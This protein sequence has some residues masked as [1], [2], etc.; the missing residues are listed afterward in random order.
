MR[1]QDDFSPNSHK[2]GRGH[3]HGHH[4]HGWN[5]GRE[6][7]AEKL[8]YCA[9]GLAQYAGRHHGQRKILRILREHSP[10][11]QKELQSIL[12]IQ[13]GSMSEIAAKLENRD[14]IVRGRDQAD[15]RKITLSITEAGLA[16]M[17]QRD[18]AEIRQRRTDF[19]SGLTQQERDTLE[20]LL[21]KLADRWEQKLEPELRDRQQNGTD[22]M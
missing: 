21:D 16:W 17:A 18:D 19:F 7:L 15:K 8:E 9:R 14:L 3:G 12:G 10:I 1:H 20:T 11:N 13:S 2:N 22:S 6:D 4:G 5:G